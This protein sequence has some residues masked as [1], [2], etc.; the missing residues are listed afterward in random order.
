MVIVD[1]RFLKS[2]VNRAH[3]LRS[4]ALRFKSVVSGNDVGAGHFVTLHDAD[5]VHVSSPRG[6]EFEQGVEKCDG[7]WYLTDGTNPL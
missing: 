4:R 7:M 5:P 2:G 6:D 3:S 1:L